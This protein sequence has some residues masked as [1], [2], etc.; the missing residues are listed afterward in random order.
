M[1]T[2][3]ST[4]GTT[5]GTLGTTP[6]TR[7]TPTQAKEVDLTSRVEE[8]DDPNAGFNRGELYFEDNEWQWAPEDQ[9]ETYTVARYARYTGY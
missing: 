2:I 4:L 9:E 8:V 1:G 3:P 6:S 5:P 7:N